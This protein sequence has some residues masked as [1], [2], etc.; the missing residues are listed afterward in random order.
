MTQAVPQAVANAIADPKAYA[1]GKPVDEAFAWL[2]A[3]APFARLE[4]EGYDPIWVVTRHA[5]LMEMELRPDIWCSGANMPVLTTRAVLDSRMADGF[6]GARTLVSM[7][8][9]DH[10]EFRRL[11]QT[12]FMPKNLKTI[13]DR[14]R[15]LAREAVD[16]MVS[17]GNFCDFARDIALFYPLRVIMEILGMPPQD[18]PLMIKLTQDIF[19]TRD[20]D[21]S[22]GGMAA[23][24][25]VLAQAALQKTMVEMQAYFTQLTLDRRQHPTADLT[26]TIANGMIRG[27]PIG[28]GDA[29]GYYIIS[30][31]AGHDTTS[32][33]T[34][35]AMWVLAE[36]PDLLARLK[37]EPELVRPFIDEAVRWASVVKHFVRTAT[38]D[39]EFA[40]QQVRKGDLVML[41]YHS[42]NRDEA[43]FDRPF[44]F[45]IDRNPNRH[46]AYGHG[47]HKCLGQHLANLEMRL[48]WEELLP[49]LEAVE[50]NG[51]PRRTEANFVCGPKSVPIAYRLG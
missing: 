13:E 30:A 31:T 39:A 22:S 15:A 35:A 33:T 48:F 50:L 28:M 21:L 42:A 24:D 47:P 9:P 40:G 23:Q 1:A 26:S 17:L 29:I 5:D 44:E 49:R 3:H 7:D 46:V 38:Q 18:E 25:P 45:D 16:R 11:T 4:P 12:W 32:N 37:A 10:P 14:V 41:S 6:T 27:E 2:R 36:R 51:E 19:G 34:S 8:P 43:V 20:A